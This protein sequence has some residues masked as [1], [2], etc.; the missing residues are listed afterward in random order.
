MKLL[1]GINNSFL[2]AHERDIL[3]SPNDCLLG[4]NTV[5]QD[6]GGVEIGMILLCR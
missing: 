4:P 6:Y 2:N 3:K 1:K 5:I